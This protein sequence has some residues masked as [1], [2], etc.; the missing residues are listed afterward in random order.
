VAT[1]VLLSGVMSTAAT[2]QHLRITHRLL[3]L[4]LTYSVRA[5]SDDIEVPPLDDAGLVQKG[6]ACYRSY[7]AECHGAPGV[8]PKPAALGM[9][10]IPTNLA[11]IAGGQTPQWLYYVTSKGVRMTGMP[12]WEFRLADESLWAVVAFLKTLPALSAADYARLSQHDTAASCAVRAPDSLPPMADGDVLLR[13]YACHSCHVIEGV[14]GPDI[15]V[16]PRL[17]DWP[18][19]AMISGTL[20]NTPENLARFIRAPQEHQ[21]GSLMPD[22]G[23]TEAD[24]RVMAAFLFAQK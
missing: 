23:V 16:G 2:K 4:G 14:V 10:P 15:H 1:A 13:Q 3:D 5:N 8:A 20:P 6:S 12:A 22:L 21:P 19:R 9:M 17:E 7:C 18:S 24:A 11:G